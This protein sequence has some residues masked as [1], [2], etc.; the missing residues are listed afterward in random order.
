MG[1]TL[2]I[3]L[4]KTTKVAEKRSYF[5]IHAYDDHASFQFDVSDRDVKRYSR[6]KNFL[7]MLRELCEDENNKWITEF[8]DMLGYAFEHQKAIYINGE[9]FGF[10]DYKWFAGAYLERSVPGRY[11]LKEV[12]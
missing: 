4:E 12:K 2:S 9:M 7:T 6:K 5:S 8:S 3:D 10:D 11:R 1:N